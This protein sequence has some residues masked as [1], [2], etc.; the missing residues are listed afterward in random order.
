MVVSQYDSFNNTGIGQI[1]LYSSRGHSAGGG[2]KSTTLQPAEYADMEN[3]YELVLPYNRPA[4]E[5]SALDTPTLMVDTFNTDA[6]GAVHNVKL[7]FDSARSLLKEYVV[8]VQLNASNKQVF[9]IDGNETPYLRLIKGF[10][11]RFNMGANTSSHPWQLSTVADGSHGGGTQYTTGV[12]TEN[13]VSGTYVL[14]TVPIDLTSNKLYYY[15]PNHPGMGGQIDVIYLDGELIPP[16]SDTNHVLRVNST[17]TGYVWGDVSEVP[18]YLNTDVNKVLTVTPSTGLGYSWQPIEDPPPRVFRGYPFTLGP[19]WYQGANNALTEPNAIQTVLATGWYSAYDGGFGTYNTLTDRSGSGG[20]TYAYG[21]T[22]WNTRDS[23]GQPNSDHFSG[24]R[25]PVS[26]HLQNRGVGPIKGDLHLA[27]VMH[28]QRIGP[29][30]TDDS[31]HAWIGACRDGCAAAAAPGDEPTTDLTAPIATRNYLHFVNNWNCQEVDGTVQNPGGGSNAGTT[32]NHDLTS[33]GLTAQG[34]GSLTYN[35]G[36]PATVRAG[37]GVYATMSSGNVPSIQVTADAGFEIEFKVKVHTWAAFNY[38]FEFRDGTGATGHGDNTIRCGPWQNNKIHIGGAS[39][40]N[41]AGN[42]NS[43]TDQWMYSETVNAFTTGVWYVIKLEHTGTDIRLYVDGVRQALANGLDYLSAV[44]NGAVLCAGPAQRGTN[45][46]FADAQ[47][48]YTTGDMEMETFV[49]KETVLAYTLPNRDN[50]YFDAGLHTTMGANSRGGAVG[51]TLVGGTDSSRGAY[52]TLDAY[53]QP[54]A[55]NVGLNYAPTLQSVSQGYVHSAAVEKIKTI[56]G[57]LSDDRYKHSEV[58]VTDTDAVRWL[59]QVPVRKYTKRMIMMRPS[60]EEVFESGRDGFA[61]RK[62][63]HDSWARRL[64][65]KSY[66]EIGVIA[67]DLHQTELAHAVEVGD[68]N[69]EWKVRYEN[70][71]ALNTKVIQTLLTRLEALEA[72]INPPA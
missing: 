26:S 31:P 60:E 28:P 54:A 21:E 70:L 13:D 50:P 65:E 27:A 47:G 68:D 22:N 32:T 45:A 67:Q 29:L 58:E 3:G 69:T 15:C 42:L 9:Y 1:E 41:A 53:Q 55:A 36:P 34:S 12:K 57:D 59:K 51:V 35:T 23:G 25:W 64:Y 16:V 2:V 33:A 6:N 46:L 24:L 38:F 8:S 63:R 11:Y 43:S 62:D 5:W 44:Q 30:D 61:S 48:N 49:V 10:S 66:G 39:S 71:T 37:N 4:A 7:K 18:S 40:Y 52:I 19:G 56:S 72:H 17:A 14:F 20:A